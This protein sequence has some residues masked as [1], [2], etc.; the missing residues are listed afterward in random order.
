MI[1]SDEEVD[2]V[3]EA[4]RDGGPT[5]VPPDTDIPDLALRLQPRYVGYGKLDLFVDPAEQELV[6]T[7]EPR[8]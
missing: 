2:N 6:L 1:L 8:E 5:T 3:A 4:L 7:L